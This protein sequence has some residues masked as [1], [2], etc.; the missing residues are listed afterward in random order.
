MNEVT[1]AFFDSVDEKN[2]PFVEDLHLL[3]CEH[4]CA[5]EIK[6]AKSGY[7]VSYSLG[8]PKRT[9]ATFVFRKS[10]VKL[11]MFLE[12]LSHYEDLLEQA[13]KKVQKEMQK[14]SDCKR[15][16]HPEDCNQKCKMGYRYTLNGTLMQ[17]CRYMAFMPTLNEEN[18]GWIKDCLLEELSHE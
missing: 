7:V 3:L 11:R 2:R 17:K 5:C 12:H 14:A 16:L 4:G 8:K 10:G 6:T 9:L 1:Q 13:P 18:N 15:L